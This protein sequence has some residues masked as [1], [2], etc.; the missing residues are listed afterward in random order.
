[1]TL[2]KLLTRGGLLIALLMLLA[3]SAFAQGAAR[4]RFIHVI[5][6]A[7]AIDIYINGAL[8]LKGLDYGTPTTYLTVPAGTH[9]VSITPSGLKSV[10]AEQPLTLSADSITTFV[11]S[12]PATLE[13]V[14]FPEK[15]GDPTLGKGRLKIIHA[16]ASL[17]AFDLQAA[18]DID[19]GGAVTTA[20]T[21]IVP[22]LTYNN[23]TEFDLGA[24][25]YPLQLSAN[26]SVI[27]GDV[28][29]PVTSG[30]SHLLIVYGPIDAP[31]TL[32]V[33]TPT[34]VPSGTG[35]VR[36]VHGI[37]GAP[38]VDILVNDTLIAPALSTERPTEH[39]G[40]PSGEHSIV[41]RAA[42]SEDILYEG[43]ITV[44]AGA[45]ETIVILQGDTEIELQ[46]LE[47]AIGSV[48]A[49]SAAVTVI[50]TIPG[51]DEIG[52][53]IGDTAAGD[54]V[55]FGQGS[56]A[57]SLTPTNAPLKLDITR[58]DMIGR[59][60]LPAH[61]FYGGVYYT[62]I[63]LD[64]GSF[65]GP[66]LLVVPTALSQGLASAP[67]AGTE[68]IDVNAV[69]TTAVVDAATP[70]DQV[71]DAATPVPETPVST[72]APVATQDATIRGRVILD[73]GANLQLREY[74]NAEARSLGLAPSGTEFV[75][76]GRQG[77]PVSLTADGG[78]PTPLPDATEFVD[79][80]TLLDPADPK[81]DLVGAE[82]WINVS[83]ST[84]DGGTI[85]AWVNAQ[86]VDVRNARGEKVKLAS[87]PVIGLNVP[88]ESRSTS[89][90]SP[91]Q[92]E[93]RKT[94][95]VQGLDAS[96]NLN[97]RRTPETSGEVLGRVGNGTVLDLVGLNE[98]EE[99]AYV[100]YRPE[101]GGTVSGWVSVEYLKYQLNSKDID[102][103]ALKAYI[104]S[105]TYKPVYEV[106][107]DDRRGSIGSGVETV[108]LPTAD[109]LKNAFVAEVK[110]DQGA[111]LQ[112]RRN[113]SVDAESLQLI[114]SGTQIVVTARTEASDWL[115]VEFEG[116]EGW[117]SARY[118]F[119]T[120]NGN[121]A[122]IE[123]IPVFVDLTTEGTAT[124][125]EGAAPAATTAP[126]ESAPVVPTATTAS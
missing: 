107:P 43:S 96:T 42:G 89:I 16:S 114:P 23:S 118:V 12:D 77:P 21:T 6:G 38:A 57:T 9:T 80:A 61:T 41:L 29:V 3:T 14:G 35:F 76:N 126:T 95:T 68:T 49:G 94:A 54:S 47:D 109:P 65:S 2:R 20:G 63:A 91:T 119:L 36:F 62:L 8:A 125:A 92:P 53:L 78:T 112:L 106:V 15:L 98:A 22:G 32:L 116:D 1:M 83:Y 11:A 55:P 18:E 117:V 84:P 69:P 88:G 110:L 58:G 5:P 31:Q 86:F 122:E 93:D 73:P 72:P 10:L 121:T 101:S 74:P 24:Q 102:L 85:I 7:A 105:F 75:V 82:T 100:T 71:I 66:R 46:P 115:R 56:A 27:L 33:N 37:V 30:T 52:V 60:D 19:V 40:L 70:A 120:Y 48:T 28:N 13:F 50:N 67:G 17:P 103:E 124:P 90:T 108:T 34:S 99:W 59:I 26:D 51:T 45:A 111:N 39:L 104:S 79:P 64:G 97:I 44:T 4:V 113:P 81:A 25:S 123:D 87:L